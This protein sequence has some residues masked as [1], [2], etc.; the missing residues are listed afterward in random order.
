[1]KVR[2]LYP[3]AF[4]G[5]EKPPEAGDVIDVDEADAFIAAGYAEAVKAPK[6]D[7]PVERAVATPGTKRGPGRPRKTPKADE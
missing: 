6:A 1:M 5:R 2:V 4:A 7:R 3:L